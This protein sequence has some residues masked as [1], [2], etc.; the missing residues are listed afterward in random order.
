MTVGARDLIGAW[1]LESWS[2]VYGDGR[3]PEFPLGADAKGIIMYTADGHV[4]ATLMRGGRIARASVTETERAAA[5]ADT[6]A[7][8]GR[9]EVRDGTV[10]HSIDIA[11]DPALIGLTSTRH[12]ALEGDVL[13][14]SGPDF[15][16]GNVRMQ[17]IVWRR[18]A[19]RS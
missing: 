2:L 4:S 7:Y 13:T 11:T 17:R 1:R 3:P 10:V 9:Y 6:F 8:A 5:F 16:P 14:L 19:S 12:I 18:A 15:Q